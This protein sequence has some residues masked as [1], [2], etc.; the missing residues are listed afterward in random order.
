MGVGIDE[1]SCDKAVAKVGRFKR[2]PMGCNVLAL[3]HGDNTARVN[4]NGAVMDNVSSIVLG[5][6]VGGKDDMIT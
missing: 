6:D 2:G 3:A 1:A 4:D 5:E